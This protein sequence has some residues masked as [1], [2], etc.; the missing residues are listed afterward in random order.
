[1]ALALFLYF[2]NKY[3]ALLPVGGIIPGDMRPG[4]ECGM[5]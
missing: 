4:T 2:E 5:I 1:M 3:V